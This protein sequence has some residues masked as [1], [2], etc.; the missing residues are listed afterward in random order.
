MA[1]DPITQML[2]DSNKWSKDMSQPLSHLAPVVPAYHNASYLNKSSIA[3]MHL[4]VDVDIFCN[5]SKTSTSVHM[6]PHAATKY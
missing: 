2:K 4:V 3:G 1:K 5:F 6:R